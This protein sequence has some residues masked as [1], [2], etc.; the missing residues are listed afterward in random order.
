[1]TRFTLEKNFE[2]P[3]EQQ[4][5]STSRYALIA[6]RPE[7][8]RWHQIRRHLKHIAHP[9]IGDHRHGDN[10]H[11]HRFEERLGLS[12]MLLSA[13]ILS[14]IHP[15]TKQPL[16]IE[17]GKGS[18]FDRILLELERLQMATS[19]PRNTDRPC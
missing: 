7:T 14:F 1:M 5:F 15:Y 9:I 13:N 16:R 10:H 4:G 2:I 3:W 18:E 6:A 17:A 11:N 12:R 8:G 19:A